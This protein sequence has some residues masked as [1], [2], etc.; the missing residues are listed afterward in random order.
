MTTATAPRKHAGATTQVTATSYVGKRR[1]PDAGTERGIWPRPNNHIPPIL[2][3]VS[4]EKDAWVW[5]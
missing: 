3:P 5:E 1:K 2:D 4:R